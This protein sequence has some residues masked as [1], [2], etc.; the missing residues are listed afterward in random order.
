MGIG[1]GLFSFLKG[2][3]KAHTRTYY[4]SFGKGP[5]GSTHYVCSYQKASLAPLFLP[6]E[7]KGR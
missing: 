1:M 7:G 6:S 5:L 4:V 3:G 2:K